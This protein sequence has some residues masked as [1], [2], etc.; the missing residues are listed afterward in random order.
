MLGIAIASAVALAAGLA[1][2]PIL[3]E[4]FRAKGVGTLANPDR[5]ATHLAKSGTPDMGGLVL[6]VAATLGYVV[7]HARPS[8]AGIEFRVMSAPGLLV[9]LAAWGQGVVGAV[10]DVLKITRR[11]PRGLSRRKKLVA[12]YGVAGLA[13]LAAMH[14]AGLPARVSLFGG[15]VGPSLPAL[16][17]VAWIMFVVAGTTNGVNLA[18]GIDGLSAGNAAMLFFVFIFFGFWEFRHPDVYGALGGS[19][20]LLDVAIASAALFGATIGFLWWNAPPARLVM[21]DTGALALGGAIAMLALF[22]RTQLLLPLMGGLFV[23]ETI[24]SWMQRQTINRFGYRFFRRAPIHHHFEEL[25]WP[26]PLILVRFWLV[27][28]VLLGAG[29]AAFYAHYLATAAPGTP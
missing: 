7:A 14:W 19:S 18:D 22:T 6:L 2:C 12:T 25:G 26:E 3:I 21:G 23:V 1:L 20:G 28:A 10:D 9:L 17:F 11:N 8:R 15:D 5:P 16:V 13:C 27:A 24:S 29:L 4:F